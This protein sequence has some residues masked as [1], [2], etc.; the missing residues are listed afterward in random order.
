MGCQD[1]WGS[2]LI[3]RFVKLIHHRVQI[4]IDGQHRK[5]C[6]PFTCVAIS[7]CVPNVRNGF[8]NLVFHE[9]FRCERCRYGGPWDWESWVTQTFWADD[10]FGLSWN[11]RNDWINSLVKSTRQQPLTD[12]DCCRDRQ[13]LCWCCGDLHV[14]S[15]C[16][17]LFPCL[18]GSLKTFYAHCDCLHLQVQRLGIAEQTFEPSC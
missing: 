5:A 11:F 16:V 7:P 12:L 8:D 10:L 4:C 6:N 13:Q 1:D 18:Q 15:K 2:F 9:Q 17:S 14:F 3:P